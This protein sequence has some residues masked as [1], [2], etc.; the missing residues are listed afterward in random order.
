MLI[1]GVTYKTV[2]R[3]DYPA[4]LQEC[5]KAGVAPSFKLIDGIVWYKDNTIEKITPEPEIKI[6][7]TPLPPNN[8]TKID[9]KEAATSILSAPP[10]A[11]VTPKK[12]FIKRLVADFKAKVFPV[13]F[14][15]S[16]C[17]QWCDKCGKE[18][19]HCV[20]SSNVMCLTCNV[21]YELK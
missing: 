13:A 20:G 4:Y 19:N 11:V 17:Y 8:D 15:K 16:N 12:P 21:G 18:T 6:S 10:L 9:L 14:G 7:D 1:E 2:E 3:K 5:K